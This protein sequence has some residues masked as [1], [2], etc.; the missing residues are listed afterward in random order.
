MPKRNSAIQKDRSVLRREQSRN[1]T[2]KGQGAAGRATCN[3]TNADQSEFS[4]AS[5][6]NRNGRVG[7]QLEVL[8]LEGRD[9]VEIKKGAVGNIEPAGGIEWSGR[10]EK[11]E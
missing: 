3:S 11:P 9:K 2:C 4:D 1:Q 5:F 10:T 6:G 7:H 8:K